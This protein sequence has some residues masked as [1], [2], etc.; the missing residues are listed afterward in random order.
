M[1]TYAAVTLLHAARA[2]TTPP[3]AAIEADL[4]PS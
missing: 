3:V 2:G 4:T 1:I